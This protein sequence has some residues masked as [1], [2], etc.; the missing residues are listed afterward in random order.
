[1]VCVFVFV[2]LCCLSHCPSDS[3]GGQSSDEEREC[4]VQMD[5]LDLKIEEL[6]CTLSELADFP[7][8][9]TNYAENKAEI[10]K[11]SLQLTELQEER[12]KLAVEA[13]KQRKQRYESP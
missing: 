10:K 2:H 8:S 5:E 4:Y 1:M 12:R 13:R 7:V 11:V 6:T 3:Y 9:P